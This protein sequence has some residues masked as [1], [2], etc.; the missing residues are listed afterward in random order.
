MSPAVVRLLSI[1]AVANQAAQSRKRVSMPVHT[2]QCRCLPKDECFPNLALWATLNVSVEGRLLRYADI[3]EPCIA[4]V[5]S[6]ECGSCLR[7]ALGNGSV[8]NHFLSNH[9]GGLQHFGH[10]AGI[11]DHSHVPRP[12][13]PDFCGPF[14]FDGDCGTVFNLAS[15]T[16]GC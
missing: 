7:A 16:L 6:E 14:V 4:D 5:A 12:A 15:S 11:G 13:L 10:F 8:D 9:P 3:M 2:Q 1:L